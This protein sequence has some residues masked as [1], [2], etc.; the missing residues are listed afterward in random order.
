MRY[1]KSIS[2]PLG[3]ELEVL[4]QVKEDVMRWL[5]IHQAAGD[6]APACN[7]GSKLQGRA[8]GRKSVDI[9]LRQGTMR[10]SVFPAT[11]GFVNVPAS[12]NPKH[13]SRI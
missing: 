5:R 9:R 4:D 1:M 13:G 8:L 7:L 10:S 12:T 3:I 2:S 11:V 6:E